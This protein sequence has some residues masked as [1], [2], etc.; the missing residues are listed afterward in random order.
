MA[1]LGFDVL[2]S[3]GQVDE[4]ER[5]LHERRLVRRPGALARLRPDPF[6]SDPLKSWDVLRTLDA[7]LDGVPRDAPVLDVGSFASAIPPALAASGYTAVAGIDLDPQV[8]GMP[9]ADRVEYMF[10]DLME[11]RWPDGR[12]AAVTAISVIEHGFEAD[13][14][15]PEVAR[16]LAP[17]G[18][19]LF[20]TD[21]WP[22]K[23]DTSDTPLFDMTWT[24]FSAPEIEEL[25]ERARAH[26]LSPASDPGPELREVGEPPIDFAGRRYTFLHGALVFDGR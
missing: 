16:L 19:F 9:A 10:G 18:L 1:D 3:R 6:R 23:I 12:F 11:T 14:L 20:S 15:L 24:I 22:E 4:A 21:Y 26:G 25:L 13:R 2:R 5:E 17:G 8:R 7:V